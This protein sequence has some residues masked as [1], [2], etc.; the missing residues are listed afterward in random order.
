MNYISP[1]L[2]AK[3]KETDLLT[4]L[5]RVAPNELVRVSNREYKT[6]SHGSLRISDGKWMWWSRGI[7]GRSAIDYLVKVEGMTFID[8]VWSVLESDGTK[9]ISD[10]KVSNH[11][12]KKQFTLPP[13]APNNKRAIQYLKSRGIPESIINY[14][15]GKGVLY[16]SDLYHNVVFVGYDEDRIPRYAA[17]RGTGDKVFKGEVSGSD[18]RFA[19]RFVNPKSDTLLVFE[20]AI[21][22]LSYMALKQLYRKQPDAEN[23]LSLSGVHG[24]ADSE[25]RKLPIALESFL[26]HGP[27]IKTIYLHLD[28]DNVGR[29]ASDALVNLLPIQYRVFDMPVPNG[30]DVNDY[31]KYVLD[32]RKQKCTDERVDR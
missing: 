9:I 18:K 29:R 4:Y 16:E 12:P 30:K 23:L 1:E 26:E 21:D 17:L 22:L 28:N 27:R 13:A 31:L 7:G 14:C 10:G 32:D 20:G 24:F 15:I 25:S 8:A 2:I 19:F 6:A 5:M 3:A 11:Q